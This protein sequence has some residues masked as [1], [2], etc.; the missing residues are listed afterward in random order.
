M[1]LRKYVS[2]R[3]VLAVIG[4]LFATSA[5]ESFRERIF[6]P[7]LLALRNGILNLATLWVNS[8]ADDTYRAVA[9]GVADAASRRT[10]AMITYF[11]ISLLAF[12]VMYEITRTRSLLR[13]LETRSAQVAARL[14]VLDGEA[15]AETYPAENERE[16]LVRH[17]SE[18]GSRYV[19]QTRW[20]AVGVVIPLL[21]LGIAL[22]VEN[23]QANYAS[24]AAAHVEQLIAITAPIMDESEE[25]KVRSRFAQIQTREEY[26]NVVRHLRELAARNKLIVPSFSIW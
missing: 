23:V 18:F 26:V 24:A 25:E 1:D 10:L 19:Q 8:L 11:V 5:L 14:K 7:S 20:L 21:F 17:Q 22:I 16:Q 4:T 6:E 3:T 15:P 9:Q 12:L 13:R 2:K